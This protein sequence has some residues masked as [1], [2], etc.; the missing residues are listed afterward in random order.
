VDDDR[1]DAALLAATA[2]DPEAFAS[3]YRRH[4]ADVLAFHRRRTGDAQLALDLTAETFARAL[5]AAATY[6]EADGAA[7]AWLFAI[8]RNLLADSYRRGRVRDDARRRLGIAA[9]LVTD[10]G[11]ERVEEICEAATRLREVDLTDALS[12]EQARAVTAR[13]IHDQPY[14][15]IAAELRCSP[16]VARQHVSRGLRALRRRLEN[17]T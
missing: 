6:R 13:V 4:V 5:R 11:F 8:A 17:G 3:F 12:A 14:E 15:Q 9:M 16:Q 1:T 10:A 7:V 2:S